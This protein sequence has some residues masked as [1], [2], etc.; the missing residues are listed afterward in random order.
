M[1]LY[2]IKKGTVVVMT[3]RLAGNQSALSSTKLEIETIFMEH[4]IVKM[5]DGQYHFRYQ[6]VDYYVAVDDVRIVRVK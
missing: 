1:A 3:K 5:I 4:D 6:D 2:V